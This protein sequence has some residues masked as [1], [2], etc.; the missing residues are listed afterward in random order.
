M[1]VLGGVL[2][3]ALEGTL[4]QLTG[5]HSAAISMMIPVMLIPPFVVFAFLPET[6]TRELEDIA[7]E[8]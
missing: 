3:L 4:Y 6:A 2:G 7:P 8:R 1:G 5:S